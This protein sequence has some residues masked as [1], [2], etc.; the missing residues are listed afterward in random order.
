MFWLV[1]LVYC[2]DPVI[3]L[4]TK[5]AALKLRWAILQSERPSRVE[6]ILGRRGIDVRETVTAGE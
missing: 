6:F 5:Q 4:R 2:R 3:R 1:I